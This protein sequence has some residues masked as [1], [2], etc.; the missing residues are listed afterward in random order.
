M[1]NDVSEYVKLVLGASPLGAVDL[2]DGGEL[3]ESVAVGNAGG[4]TPVTSSRRPEAW[5]RQG[6]T[7]FGG[8]IRP[9]A[10]CRC[11]CGVCHARGSVHSPFPVSRRRLDERVV[12]GHVQYT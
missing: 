9:V 6:E 7:S 5:E 8:E 1:I 2:E 11:P 10:Y 12:S 4:T 3:M